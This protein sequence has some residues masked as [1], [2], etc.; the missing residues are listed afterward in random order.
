MLQLSTANFVLLF[1]HQLSNMMLLES[2]PKEPLAFE[3]IRFDNQKITH[4]F[5]VSLL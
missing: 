1:I 3:I 4:T 5:V 2:V